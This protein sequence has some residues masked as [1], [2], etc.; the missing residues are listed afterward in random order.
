MNP[1]MLSSCEKQNS[2]IQ[3]IWLFLFNTSN[4]LTAS[5]NNKFTK[6][7]EHLHKFLLKLTDTNI[8]STGN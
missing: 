7:I 2:S 5:F 6:K 1:N 8:W 3:V 4:S